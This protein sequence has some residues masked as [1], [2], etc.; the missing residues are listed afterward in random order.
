MIE[1]TYKYA[2]LED[3]EHYED[4][5]EFESKW[6]PVDPEWIAEDAADYEYH[7]CDGWDRS[8]PLTFK[9]WDENG[10][11]LGSFLVDLEF[12]PTFS[13]HPVAED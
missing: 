11:E 1:K 12:D 10:V 9:I 7:D 13:A 3:H 4:A 5:R 6:G 8:W 2:V